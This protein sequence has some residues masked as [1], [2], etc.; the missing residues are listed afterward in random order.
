LRRFLG[1]VEERRKRSD[2]TDFMSRKNDQDVNE[3]WDLAAG[4]NALRSVLAAEL[5]RLEPAHPL[6][7]NKD[8]RLAIEE[9]GRSR[10]IEK[11]RRRL[12]DANMTDAGL[13]NFLNEG[14]EEIAG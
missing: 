6:V 8:L 1:A 4:L 14:L 11:G 7:T 10:F 3:A 13:I 2:F 12:V 9:E 5:A